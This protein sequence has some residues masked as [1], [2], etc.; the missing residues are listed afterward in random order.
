MI[1]NSGSPAEGNDD[2]NDTDLC[3]RLRS[4]NRR[5]WGVRFDHGVGFG[6][7]DGPGP[8]CTKVWSPNRAV[9]YRSALGFMPVLP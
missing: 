8:R 5:F 7:P 2:D 9:V 6:R 4:S 3:L 1:L